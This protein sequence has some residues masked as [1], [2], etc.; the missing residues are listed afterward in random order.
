M[1]VSWGRVTR[2]VGISS[3][4]YFFLILLDESLLRI[5]EIYSDVIAV[6]FDDVNRTL[7][8]VD[9]FSFFLGQESLGDV[10]D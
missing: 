10:V 9:V 4:S 2:A 7:I 6:Q 5:N 8:S 1:A 3:S